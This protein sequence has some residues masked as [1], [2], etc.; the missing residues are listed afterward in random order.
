MVHEKKRS[1]DPDYDDKVP[2]DRQVREVVTADDGTAA[3]M[4]PATGPSDVFGA[5][6]NLDNVK[7][8]ETDNRPAPGDVAEE[9]SEVQTYDPPEVAG[10]VKTVPTSTP[11]TPAPKGQQGS[12]TRRTQQ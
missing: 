5:H 8:D 2:M 6:V 7:G 3:F 10:A 11:R 9:E 4:S 12:T 1:G